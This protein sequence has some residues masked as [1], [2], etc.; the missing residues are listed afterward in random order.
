[1][2]PGPEGFTV[3]PEASDFGDTLRSHT[4]VRGKLA[5]SD[6]T[7]ILKEM[8]DTQNNNEPQPTDA[9]LELIS[10]EFFRLIISGQ[11]E[12]RL[13]NT[14]PPYIL[15]QEVPGYKPIP[16]RQENQPCSEGT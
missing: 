4:V 6:K 13:I 11:P 12:T 1:M 15:S 2:C 16:D 5:G 14:N 8:V 7:W 10:Q 3:S 9:R